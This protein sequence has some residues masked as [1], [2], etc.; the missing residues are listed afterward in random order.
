MT[1]KIEQFLADHNPPTPCLILDLDVVRENYARLKKA[2]PLADIYYASKANPAPEILTTLA[3]LGSCFDAASIYEIDS[4]LTVGADPEHI[5]FGN[6]IK[7]PSD[8]EHAFEK[9][10]RLFAFDSLPELEKLAD[11]APGSK[12]FCRILTSDEG[13][14]W[15]LSAKFGCEL[16]MAR[17][18]MIRAQQMELDPYG[19]SFHVG[20]QQTDGEQWEI[21]IARAAMV[22]SDLREA[23]IELK[24][25][26]L[27][28]GLPASYRDE[29]PNV[30]HYTDKIMKAMTGVFSN[31]LPHMIVEPGRVIAANAG[32]IQSEVVL[33]S[34]KSYDDK[35]R[36]IYLD[37]GMFS[38][39][40]EATGE[41]IQYPIRTAHDGGREGPVVIA[42]P[43]CDGIDVIYEKAEYTLPLALQPGDRIQLLNTGVYTTSYSSVGFN[44]FPPLKAFYI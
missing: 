9:G 31:D 42:G 25:I 30:E 40:T 28:G 18:L 38:G 15:P 1:P 5:S 33:I 36:W 11:K 8:I 32:L 43:T 14:Q 22:F 23:G 27:G 16:D 35:V 3:Q 21:A 37:V 44:G 10:I 12:V 2:L 13:S 17:D 6:T 34:N 20:S 7:K 29:V 41:A 4:C 39:M 24:M 19:I 26:N